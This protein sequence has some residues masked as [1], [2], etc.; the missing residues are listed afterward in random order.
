MDR[1]ILAIL[2]CGAIMTIEDA[3]RP[4]TDAELRQHVKV[5]SHDRY[6]AAH[7]FLDALEMS[8]EVGDDFVFRSPLFG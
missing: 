7:K 6:K 3:H 1:A 4:R 5:G 8:A 2:T